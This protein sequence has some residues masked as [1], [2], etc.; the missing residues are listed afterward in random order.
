MKAPG[1]LESEGLAI[2]PVTKFIQG[3]NAVDFLMANLENDLSVFGPRR[4]HWISRILALACA[5]V[6]AVNVVGGKRAQNI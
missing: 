2:P 5:C 4:S 3:R 6:T 1:Q